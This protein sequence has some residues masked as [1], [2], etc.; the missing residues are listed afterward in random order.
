M[1]TMHLADDMFGVVAEKLTAVLRVAG[2][3]PA[4]NE[5]L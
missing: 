5:Y 3:I 4:G 2:S 1:F